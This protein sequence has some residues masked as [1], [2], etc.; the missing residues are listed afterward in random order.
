MVFALKTNPAN[1]SVITTFFISTLLTA[2]NILASDWQ[3]MV[4]DIREGRLKLSLKLTPEERES[5]EKAMGGPNPSRAGE[6]R[7]IF[8]SASSTKFNKIVPQLWPNVDLV[9]VLC[10]G[11]FSHYIPRLQYF[12]GE[13]I[14]LFSFMYVSSEGLLGVNKWPYKRTS[15]YALL[16]ETN[17]YEFIPLDQAESPSPE[18]LLLDEVKIGEH[19]EIVITTGEGLYRYRLGDI[20]TVVEKSLEGPVIDV[21]GRKKMAINLSGCKLYA[22][23]VNSAI[24][25]FTDHLKDRSV[26][27][28]Y[29]ISA[30]TSVV[31]PRYVVWLECDDSHVSAAEAAAIIE[32][33]LNSGN[34]EYW[35]SVEDGI[36]GHLVV[37]LLKLGSIADIKCTLKQFSPVGEVQMKLP[38]VVWDTKLLDLLENSTIA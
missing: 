12:L 1:A 27:I 3:Q 19:Y 26:D 28:D 17:F 5:L 10:G 38:R 13:T 21:V 6:L 16:S 11:E 29:L 22:F 15:A 31:P 34:L 35:G 25:V 33:H 37:K 32:K 2:F 24:S 7:S 23:Q 30:D 36:I 18:V 9:S 14:S 4:N 20:I 8:E